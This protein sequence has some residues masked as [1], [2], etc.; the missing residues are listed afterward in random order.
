LFAICFF[1]FYQDE[2]EKTK[3]KTKTKK[4]IRSRSLLDSRHSYIR[5]KQTKI[6]HVQKKN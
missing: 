6:L 3:T 4:Q 5:E 2:K 1:A